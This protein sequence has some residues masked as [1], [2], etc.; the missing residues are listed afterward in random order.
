MC[1]APPIVL[2]F[3]CCRLRAL[4]GSHGVGSKGPRRGSQRLPVDMQGLRHWRRWCLRSKRRALR[5]FSQELRKYNARAPDDQFIAKRR[6][7][8][9][10]YGS[11][12]RSTRSAPA[13]CRV[14]TRARRGL[15]GVHRAES[16]RTGLTR[17]LKC[18][19]TR[20]V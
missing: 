5:P 2:L 13:V 19:E 10:F 9:L 16:M 8:C 1:S 18:N 7:W 3:W 20:C 14:P 17:G 6:Q 11:V 15:G 12:R 4:W